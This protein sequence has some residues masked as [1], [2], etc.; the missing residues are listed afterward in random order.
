MIIKE[1]ITQIADGTLT[2]NDIIEYAAQKEDKLDLIWQ[3]HFANIIVSESIGLPQVNNSAQ[4]NRI[5]D[6]ISYISQKFNLS[7]LDNSE[8]TK[9]KLPPELYSERAQYLFDKAIE[10][11]LIT[12]DGTNLKWTKK[13]V[14]L[15]YFLRSA[16][17]YE[18]RYKK[19]LPAQELERL[20]NVS[21][22]SKAVSQLSDND[23]GKPKI[24]SEIIDRLVEE[25]AI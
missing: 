11:G 12:I 19:E 18:C 6:A 9:F 23:K 24:D 2:K 8:N 7:L 10:V 15:A 20:F 3:L 25:I 14:L 22:L 13:K 16:Y 1:F 4:I 21:R 17:Q 5:H